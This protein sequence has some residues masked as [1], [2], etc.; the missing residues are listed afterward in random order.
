MQ[1][2]LNST[3]GKITPHRK[4]PYFG[5]L[6]DFH[7]KWCNATEIQPDDLHIN[8]VTNTINELTIANSTANGTRKLLRPLGLQSS[9]AAASETKSK[10][11]ISKNCRKIS[12]NCQDIKSTIL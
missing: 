7:C 1:M 9:T 8:D 5:P 11:K 6:C 12:K 4:L 2:L 3:L 10:C